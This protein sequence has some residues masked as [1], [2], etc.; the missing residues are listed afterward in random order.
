MDQ[1]SD[2][3]VWASSLPTY[4]LN[5]RFNKKFFSIPTLDDPQ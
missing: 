1:L 4:Q 5:G 2:T 3:Q